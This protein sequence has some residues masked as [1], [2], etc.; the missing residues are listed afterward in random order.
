MPLKAVLRTV[1]LFGG[2][3]KVKFHIEIL[4]EKNAG[5]DKSDQVQ[6]NLTADSLWCQ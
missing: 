2:E 1:P 3:E 5:W 6:L 4:Q